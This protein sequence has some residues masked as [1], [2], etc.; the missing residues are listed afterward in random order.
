MAFRDI[1]VRGAAIASG[2]NVRES[3]ILLLP[4]AGHRKARRWGVGQRHEV[5][6]ICDTRLIGSKVEMGKIEAY[7]HASTQSMTTS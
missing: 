7:V 4:T 3:T 6:A 1:K 5:H 2:L